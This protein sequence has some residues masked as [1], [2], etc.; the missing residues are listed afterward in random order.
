MLRV[1]RGVGLVGAEFVEIVV[2]RYIVEG[3]D[4]LIRVEGTLDGRQLCSRVNPVGRRDQIQQSRTSDRGDARQA[5]PL[6]K[7]SAVEVDSFGRDVGIAEI[8]RSANQHK[9]PLDC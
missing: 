7:R 9:Y 3:S 6:Q 8:S 5:Q 1:F 4:F 2:V